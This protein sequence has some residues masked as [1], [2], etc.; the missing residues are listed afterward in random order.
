MIEYKTAYQQFK[1]K[2]QKDLP[3]YAMLSY[4]DYPE[5]VKNLSLDKKRAKIT[6]RTRNKA[7]ITLN[8]YKA[9]TVG[10]PLSIVFA[11]AS[12]ANLAVNE[13]LETDILAIEAGGL[14]VL[15]VF[16][17]FVFEGVIAMLYPIFLA[18]WTLASV[19]A[20]LRVT[21]LGFKV[22]TFTINATTIFGVGLAI[23]FALFIHQRFK[24][25]YVRNGK[26]VKAALKKSLSTSGRAVLFS[27]CTL[28]AC[29]AGA[30]QFN[31]FY[32]TTMA[33][34]VMYSAMTACIGAFTL[35]PLMYILFGDRTFYLN[36]DRFYAGLNWIFS[37]LN[38]KFRGNTDTKP[39]SDAAEVE[40]EP[41]K[42]DPR[43]PSY[44]KEVT[45]GIWYRTVAYVMKHPLIFLAVI[46]GCLAGLMYVFIDRVRFGSGGISL[47][48]V[49][50][51]VRESF[52]DFIRYI[53][54]SQGAVLNVYMETKDPLGT[55]NADFLTAL[56]EYTT[57]VRAVPNVIGVRN[58]V[59][60]N[61]S[62]TLPSYI[63]YYSDPFSPAN[64]PFTK[65]LVEPFFITDFKA[66]STTS[67]F[68]AIDGNDPALFNSIR[69]IRRLT[70]E[71]K[72]TSY[73]GLH[74]VTGGPAVDYDIQQDV[75]KSLPGFIAVILCSMFIFLF[76][77]TGSLVIPLKAIITAVLSIISSFAFLVL[78][79]QEGPQSA[80]DL[81]KFIPNK[82]LDP[83]NLLFIFA[84]AFGLS[85]DYEIFM[86]SRIYE[87]WET[88][89]DHPHA[90][91]AGIQLSAKAITCAAILLCVVLGAFLASQII[92]LKE[93]GMVFFTLDELVIVDELTKHMH[94]ALGLQS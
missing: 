39:S 76:F 52:N 17:V 71:S 43:G 91:A 72:V 6:A 47:L 16:I 78:V 38:K 69:K 37:S 49:D 79:F 74:G 61:S 56:D 12:L 4:F 93:I 36:T 67:V 86:I 42:V 35:L 1:T 60:F 84:V 3:V 25:E 18:I 59:R 2:I 57:A 94:R 85:L 32:L 80:Q 29:L 63:S 9:T 90:V 24:D 62:V 77:L 34:A 70:G 10:N 53:P 92:A 23:D 7:T 33:L 68:F 73:L 81:L 44:S 41:T 55:R 22:S 14:P 30:L 83:L 58:M 27:A 26:D 66:I 40:E 46:L 50:S 65:N 82:N 75:L 45:G 31:E 5:S 20:C 28:T 54:S 64:L 88:T 87:L 13:A 11:G 15:V 21:S 51:E 89:H 8:Q 19:L 48:P